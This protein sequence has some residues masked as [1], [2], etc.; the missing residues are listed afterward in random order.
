MLE[1]QG[2]L[3]KNDGGMSQQNRTQLDKASAGQM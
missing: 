2:I 1:S 3:P